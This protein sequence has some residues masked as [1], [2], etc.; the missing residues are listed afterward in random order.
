MSY[1]TA[2]GRERILV[3]L[4]HSAAQIGLALGYLGEAYEQ[5]DTM[6]ADSLEQ[7]LFSPVQAAYARA[8]R[9]RA[10]FAGRYGVAEPGE[11]HQASVSQPSGP[12]AL[13]EAAANA[14]EQADH[15]IGELQ[16]SML[17][18][19]VGDEQLRGGLSAT[20]SMLAALPARARELL[21][22]LGR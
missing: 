7:E 9:T 16:D 10:E 2:E 19:E 11:P 3:D 21:R 14:L 20:R 8:R 5:L 22:T 12:R 1:T 15:W 18:V 17:P 6:L 13:I 4:G